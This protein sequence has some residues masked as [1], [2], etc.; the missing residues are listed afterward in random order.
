MI[1]IATASL[2]LLAVGSVALLQG[3][4]NASDGREDDEGFHPVPG[5]MR[6]AEINPSV[7]PIAPDR[8]GRRDGNYTY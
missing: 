5:V 2:L 8:H 7:L 1:Y 6:G 4:R 3:V